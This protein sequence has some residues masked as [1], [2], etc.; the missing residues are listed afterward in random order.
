MLCVRSPESGM[1]RPGRSGLLWC[2][3]DVAVGCSPCEHVGLNVASGHPRDKA[4]TQAGVMRGNFV[5][6]AQM[7]LDEVHYKV[8]EESLQCAPNLF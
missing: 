3:R 1:C 6:E 4:G 8:H 2:T 5:W 7:K